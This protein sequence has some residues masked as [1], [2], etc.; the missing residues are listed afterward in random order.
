MQTRDC[1]VN[2]IFGLFTPLARWA[3]RATL[4]A[5]WIEWRAL[6]VPGRVS[7]T[8]EDATALVLAGEFGSQI[9]QTYVDIGAGHPVRYS[10]TWLL[11]QHGWRGVTVEPIESHVRLHQTYRPG[12]T[13]LRSLVGPV[14]DNAVFV[15]CEPY[16]Y[17]HVEGIPHSNSACYKV[18]DRIPIP[19][20][21][22]RDIVGQ[23]YTEIDSIGLLT[24][25]CEGADLVI[26]KSN[27]WEMCRPW[28]IIAEESG[29]DAPIEALLTG[30][31]YKLVAATILSKIFARADKLSEAARKRAT[32]IFDPETLKI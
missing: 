19:V 5:S 1:F 4:P 11:Y 26:L 24:V 12:D 8:G 21:T 31:G 25:D 20:T 28:I 17:S 22:L 3:L 15:H 23:R 10:N 2:I 29:S 13:V 7:Q 6:L 16:E 30:K 9:P 27:D 14:R 18:V 32:A